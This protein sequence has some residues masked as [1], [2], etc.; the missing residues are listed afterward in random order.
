MHIV[1]YLFTFIYKGGYIYTYPLSMAEVFIPSVEQT[2][3]AREF[4]IYPLVL[5]LNEL[6]RGCQ[7]FRSKNFLAFS[8]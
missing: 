4:I 3:R 2:T 1:I 5:D 7:D 6:E 8:R